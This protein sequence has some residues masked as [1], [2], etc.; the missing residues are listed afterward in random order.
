MNMNQTIMNQPPFFDQKLKKK[1]IVSP[2]NKPQKYFLSQH[3]G[4]THHIND[5]V[6]DVD[7][8][9][10]ARIMIVEDMWVHE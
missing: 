2:P 5:V 10:E 1:I 6:I 4:R 8:T 7:L 9:P 3:K